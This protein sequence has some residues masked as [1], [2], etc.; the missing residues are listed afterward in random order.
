[1]TKLRNLKNT[2]IKLYSAFT[3]SAKYVC[4]NCRVCFHKWSPRNDFIDCVNCKKR[5]TYAGSAFRAPPKRDVKEWAKLEILIRGGMKFHYCGGNG[6]IKGMTKDEARSRVRERHDRW[7]PRSAN[8]H[9]DLGLVKHAMRPPG[10]GDRVLV[11]GSG[12]AGYYAP[13]TYELPE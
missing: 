7:L 9:P 5:M 11:P 3:S 1:M 10:N 13:D 12:Y 2:H 6:Q 4:F 8:G